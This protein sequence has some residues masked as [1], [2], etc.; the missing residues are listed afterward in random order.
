M[1]MKISKPRTMKG[2]GLRFD[3]K[4]YGDEL[5]TESVG[6]EF[7]IR[8]DPRDLSHIWVYGKSGNLVCKARLLGLHP[9]KES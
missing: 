7:D 8:Y 9:T 4:R 2:D 3:N 6:E 5:L 1:L